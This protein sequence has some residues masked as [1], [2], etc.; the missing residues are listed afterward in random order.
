MVLGDHGPGARLDWD[1][2]N[3][4]YFANGLEFFSPS[5]IQSG[6]ARLSTLR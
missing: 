6:S 4:R 3:G 1:N 5:S 2:P